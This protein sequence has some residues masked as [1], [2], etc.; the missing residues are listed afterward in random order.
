VKPFYSEFLK[1]QQQQEGLPQPSLHE[2]H[3]IH[4]CGIDGEDTD[5][6]VW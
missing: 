5:F 2:Q 1:G 3:C 6:R 4:C